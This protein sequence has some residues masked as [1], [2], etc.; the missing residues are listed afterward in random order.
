[1]HRQIHP[2]QHAAST[3]NAGTS[4]S[5]HSTRSPVWRSAPG[6]VGGEPGSP[7]APWSRVRCAY[8]GCRTVTTEA[9]C[10]SGQPMKTCALESINQPTKSPGENAGAWSYH[11][12]ATASSINHQL[13]LGPCST[14]NLID[15]LL[16]RPVSPLALSLTRSFQL[17]LSAS[18]DRFT[19]KV[20]LMSSALPPA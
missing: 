4:R 10:Q 14:Q 17:P 5:D 9:S 3:G 8:P 2:D 12:R 20:C 11:G 18:L 1:M 15:Q 13:P 19:L 16:I 6:A 7:L